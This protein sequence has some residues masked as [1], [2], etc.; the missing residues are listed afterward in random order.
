MNRALYDKLVVARSVCDLPDGDMPIY[1]G[2]HIMSEYTSSQVFSA[3]CPK[4]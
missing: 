3:P 1:V 2:F 4:V